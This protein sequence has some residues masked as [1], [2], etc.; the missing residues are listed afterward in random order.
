MIFANANLGMFKFTPPS[1]AGTVAAVF[2]S[3]LQLG[4]AVGLAIVTSIETNVE[5]H[6]G[7][8]A[9]YKGRA[10]AFYFLFAIV[11]LAFLSTL[12]FI[13]EEKDTPHRPSAA[14]LRAATTKSKSDLQ[15]RSEDSFVLDIK[16]RT[17]I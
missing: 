13:R 8:F 3:A 10:A 17:F 1:M 12:I 2:N 9:S 16:P 4:A 14:A 15:S 7:G 5:R 6:Q 11:V